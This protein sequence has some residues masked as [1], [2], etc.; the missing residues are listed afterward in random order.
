[1]VGQISGMDRFLGTR[2]FAEGTLRLVRTETGGTTLV[3]N[4]MKVQ[5]SGKIATFGYP[6]IKSKAMSF[7][8]EFI[9][10]LRD[11]LSVLDVDADTGAV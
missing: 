7:S 10:A 6:I 4:K 1:M 11:Q 5:I 3:Y 9:A 2:V 8:N